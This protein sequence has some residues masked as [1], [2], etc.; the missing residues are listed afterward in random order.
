MSPLLLL[1]LLLIT[2]AFPESSTTRPPVVGE[3]ALKLALEAEDQSSMLSR[4]G[5]TVRFTLH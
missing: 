3:R 1:S 2:M 5:H 4:Y